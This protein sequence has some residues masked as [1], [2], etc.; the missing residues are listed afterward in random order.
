V[1]YRYEQLKAA[2]L[3]AHPNATP[4]EYQKAI[5]EIAKQLGI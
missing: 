2:W 1:N 5:R 4:T 3:S